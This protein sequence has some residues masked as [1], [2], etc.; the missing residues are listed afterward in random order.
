MKHTVVQ[1]TSDGRLESRGERRSTA[2]GEPF[3][4]RRIRVERGPRKSADVLENVLLQLAIER[5]A[6]EYEDPCRLRSVDT[7]SVHNV[8]E[9]MEFHIT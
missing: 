3:F 1:R 8:Q 4:V 6:I 2:T 9:V 5:H 7:V